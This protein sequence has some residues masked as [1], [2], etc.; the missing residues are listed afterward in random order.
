MVVHPV[1]ERIK[2]NRRHRSIPRCDAQHVLSIKEEEGGR[3]GGK[4]ESNDGMNLILNLPVGGRARAGGDTE[5]PRSHHRPLVIYVL[6]TI[7]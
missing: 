6:L 3:E 5:P 1:T 7:W 2:L 4:I